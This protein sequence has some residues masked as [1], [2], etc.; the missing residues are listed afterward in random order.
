VRSA[1]GTVRPDVA[2]ASTHWQRAERFFREAVASDPTMTEARLRLGRVIGLLGRHQEAIAE[3][4]RAVDSSDETLLRYYGEMFLG[5]EERALGRD[6]AARPHYERAARLYPSAPSP[7]LA[8]SDLG[9]RAGDRSA[10]LGAMTQAFTVA[11]DRKDA[12][13]PWWVYLIAPFDNADDLVARCRRE[14]A[15]GKRTP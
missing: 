6:A 1:D 3:L 12:S 15:A 9:H 11:A 2:S 14:F 8:L 10:A 7:Y 4:Q 13:D 5:S